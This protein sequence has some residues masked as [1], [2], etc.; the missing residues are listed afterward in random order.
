MRLLRATFKLNVPG[1]MQSSSMSEAASR[2]WRAGCWTDAASTKFQSCDKAQSLNDHAAGVASVGIYFTPKRHRL[3]PDEPPG[4]RS[5]ASTASIATSAAPS[6]Q[7]SLSDGVHRIAPAGVR[8]SEKE[9]SGFQMPVTPP[10]RLTGRR[11]LRI[12]TKKPWM[13]V[14]CKWQPQA[15]APR[16]CEPPRHPLQYPCRRLHW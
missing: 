3:G 12:A 11:L 13:Q 15:P 14:W 8:A 2:K 10:S 4:P 6:L 1:P 16:P 5:F 7:V 9:R